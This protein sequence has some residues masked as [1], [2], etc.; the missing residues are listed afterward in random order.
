[1]PI[2]R[3]MHVKFINDHILTKI[4]RLF[5]CGWL[6]LKCETIELKKIAI[7]TGVGFAAMGVI[8]FVVKLV[9]IPIN[10]ILIGG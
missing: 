5:L 9:F 8:G 7:A 2:T 6:T 10:N 1:M 3:L 4:L